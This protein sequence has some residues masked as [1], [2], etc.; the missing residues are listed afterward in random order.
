M[1][2]QASL[3]IGGCL[4][5]FWL[6]YVVLAEVAGPVP[7]LEQYRVAL[8]DDMRL[9]SGA[10]MKGNPVALYAR[11][12]PCPAL[13]QQGE[14]I[15]ALVTPFH[16]VLVPA[17]RLAGAQLRPGC[18]MNPAFPPPA[19]Y[20]GPLGDIAQAAGHDRFTM[21]TIPLW[22]IISATVLGLAAALLL[23][24]SH[25]AQMQRSAA[26]FLLAIAADG[27]L[28]S[29]GMEQLPYACFPLLRYCV[30]YLTLLG[31]ALLLNIL[32]RR[33]EHERRWAIGIYCGLVAALVAAYV[34]DA[35]EMVRPVLDSAAT[36]LVAIYAGLAMAAMLRRAPGA[37]ARTL[38]IFVV[39]LSSIAYDIAIY[40]DAGG[41]QLGLRATA[42]SPLF[43]MAALVGELSLQGWRLHHEARRSRT[44]LE[45]QMAEEDESM[46][47]PS[48]VLRHHERQRAVRA[49][50][51]RFIADIH[52]GVGGA[53]VHLLLG[54][55]NGTVSREAIEA[56][57]QS[58][59][60]DLRNI[61]LALADHHQALDETLILFRERMATRLKAAGIRLLWVDEVT[62]P[63]PAL[64]PAA[65]I[66]LLRILQESVTN[67]LKH[68]Q[69]K[70]LTLRLRS[71]GADRLTVEIA[72]DGVGFAL[73]DAERGNR[74]GRGLTHMRM[75][76][77]RLGA[78]LN[79]AS[80]PGSGATIRLTLRVAREDQLRSL[81]G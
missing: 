56:D 49:E 12:L 32:G 71:S 13:L 51:E 7:H 6:A 63:M 53:L 40:V 46:L 9:A 27:Y 2:R 41:S 48:P 14:E 58:A 1:V 38:A 19:L 25:F 10:P 3:A 35:L 68:A 44:D 59:V 52:D 22:T 4:I 77:K 75:R 34:V 33:S 20:A 54:V 42:L 62:G 79:I 64:D 37:A 67:C 81:L 69:A 16:P 80:R 61:A 39:A 18:W 57:L 11:L 55:R 8:T 5:L 29:F 47:A 73:R 70:T 50:R 28:S 65:L 60:D 26:F 17:A 43:L 66:H 24:L 30:Q 76:A 78:R 72:D 15:V 23:P 31:A 45:R 74:Q 36:L 21:R